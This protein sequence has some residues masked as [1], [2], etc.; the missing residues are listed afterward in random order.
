[1]PLTSSN[2]ATC[3]G[4]IGQSYNN[5]KNQQQQHPRQTAPTANSIHGKQHPRIK[6][7]ETD[8]STDTAGMLRRTWIDPCSSS[9]L[10]L[11]L[12]VDAVAHAFT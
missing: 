8:N 7:I 9:V 6:Q 2:G 12:S 1:M 5:Y 11:F 3:S 10:Y 4:R